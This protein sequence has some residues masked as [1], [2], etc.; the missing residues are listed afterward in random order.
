L[1]QET[2]DEPEAAIPA[3]QAIGARIIENKLA[4]CSG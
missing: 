1:H 4:G 2:F 3:L